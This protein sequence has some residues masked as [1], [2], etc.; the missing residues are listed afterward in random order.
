MDCVV[1]LVVCDG[2]VFELL[3]EDIEFGDRAEEASSDVV[4]AE[5]MVDL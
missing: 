1:R 3:L 4:V 2:D 5:G